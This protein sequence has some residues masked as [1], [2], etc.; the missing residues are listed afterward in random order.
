MTKVRPESIA[1][2]AAAAGGAT[3]SGLTFVITGSLSTMSR[4]V[5]ESKIRSLG[6]HPASSVSKKTSYV[7]T[8]EN[9][10]S[11]SEKA[12]ELGVKIISEQE[13]LKML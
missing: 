11:K 4:D 13:L 6:G 7:V 1:P 5:A 3:L 10:G 12:K 8:G 9:S 2:P